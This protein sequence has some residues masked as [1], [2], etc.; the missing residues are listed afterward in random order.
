MKKVLRNI[1]EIAKIY[2]WHELLGI[3]FTIL[4]TT[5]VFISP[6][7]SRYL[8]DE[9]IP[10][11]SVNK[12]IIGIS[13]FFGGCIGQPIFGYLKDIVFMKVSENITLLI[14]EKMFNKIINTPIDFFDKCNNGA[15]VSRI[16]N[17]GRNVSEFITNFF[18]VFV[19]NI[20]LIIMILI[21]M[22]VLSK[23]IT[24]MIVFLYAI[25]FF[26]NWKVSHKFSSMSKK[27]QESY[28]QICIK[29]NRSVGLINTIKAFN[30]EDKVK[31][32]FKEIIENN[33]LNSIKFKKLN[34]LINS[35]SNGLTI[36]SLSAV[37][38]VGSL[39]AMNGKFTIGTVVAMGLYFQLL[40]QPIYEL[41]NSNINIH[42]IIPIFNRINEYINLESE[43][44]SSEN[45]NISE[46]KKIELKNVS[47]N[48]KN[49]SQALK[50]INLE[51]PS[52][53]IFAI[54]GNSGAGKSSLIKLLS[55]F[56]SSYTGEIKINGRELKEYGVSDIRKMI[57][58]VSQD[59][60]LFNESI[61]NNIK[62]GRNVDDSKMEEVLRLLNLDNVIENLELGYDTIINE[63]A[64]LSGGEKQRLAIAR[65]LVRDSLVYIFDEPTAALDTIN[66]KRIKNILENLA[67]ERLV[68]IITH[69][70][71]LLNKADRIYTMKYGE[72]IEEGT[73]E[74]LIKKDMYFSQL[75]SELS[76]KIV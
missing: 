43:R 44:V 71:N 3:I 61:K 18:I 12:L 4:Y 21:G 63:R 2:K 14:R 47:F 56:Y 9:V 29:I 28:D 11:V 54:V 16:S 20:V 46:F 62:M 53:G 76:K 30:Q 7:A 39:L 41:I 13:I 75:I 49:G 15:I 17:D 60:E 65:A 68:I 66:E 38:G 45:G 37:Y 42:T 57:S 5:A 67:K 23:E 19:K 34:L 72:I 59:I 64:N 26:I 55:A 70:L 25:Y 69:N 6:I 1:W 73:Y 58:L 74:Y 52:K 8:I 32:E 35:V 10:S 24:L 50:N 31:E 51:L 33:Y 22:L 27:N 40:A 36:A 48:Y